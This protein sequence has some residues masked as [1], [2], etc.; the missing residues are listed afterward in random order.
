MVNNSTSRGREAAYSHASLPHTSLPQTQDSGV[1]SSTTNLLEKRHDSGHEIITAAQ[2]SNILYTSASEAMICNCPPGS[3]R[4]NGR[5]CAGCP[6]SQDVCE[7]E[8]PH[9]LTEL[10]CIDQ[11]QQND[12]IRRD[13]MLMQTDFSTDN[14]SGPELSFTPHVQH[15]NPNHPDVTCCHVKC[16]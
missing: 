12:F 5:C 10:A 9:T 13:G 1:L 11:Q 16:S 8:D 4:R 6:G 14:F 2:S 3:C 15:H 7:S